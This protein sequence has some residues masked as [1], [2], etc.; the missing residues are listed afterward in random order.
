MDDEKVI[1]AEGK[2]IAPFFSHVERKKIA[3]FFACLAL[4]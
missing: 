4:H 2:K 1:E 3:P